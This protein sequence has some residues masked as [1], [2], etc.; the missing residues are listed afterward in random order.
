LLT[1]TPIAIP[2][3]DEVVLSNRN[4]QAEIDYSV[5]TTGA[6]TTERGQLWTETGVA[7]WGDGNSSTTTLLPDSS[8]FVWIGKATHGYADRLDHNVTVVVTSSFSD[9]NNYSETYPFHYVP[10]GPAIGL[11]VTTDN[12]LTTGGTFGP[13][14]T[15]IS[16]KPGFTATVSGDTTGQADQVVYSVD[17][18]S[19]PQPAMDNGPDQWIIPLD[20]GTLTGTSATHTLTVTVLNAAGATLGSPVTDT[21]SMQQ[22]LNFGTL[23]STPPGSAPPGVDAST[24]RFFAGV[25]VEP[26]FDGTI[27]DL[28][29]YYAN[30]DQIPGVMIGDN[31]ALAPDFSIVQTTQDSAAFSFHTDVATLSPEGDNSVSLLGAAPASAFLVPFPTGSH[32]HVIA[33]PDWLRFTAAG[34]D[35][36][37][38]TYTFDLTYPVAEF[39]LPLSN[40]DS[41]DG[42]IDALINV[43]LTQPTSLGLGVNLRVTAALTTNPGDAVLKVTS[44]YATATVLGENL[45][46]KTSSAFVPSQLFVRAALDPETLEAP[47]GISLTT[48]QI[49]IGDLAN[50]SLFSKSF[51]GSLPLIFPA[52]SLL[53]ANVSIKTTFQARLTSLAVSAALKLDVTGFDPQLS[54]GTF[55]EVDA[56]GS[57]A[58]TLALG[59]SISFLGIPLVNATAAGY[60]AAV[61]HTNLRLDFTGPI[62][63]PKAMLDPGSSAGINFGYGITYGYSTLGKPIQYQTDFNPTPISP[64]LFGLKP[65]PS[66]DL[67]SLDD[68]LSGPGLLDS[69]GLPGVP[70][71]IG[72]VMTVLGSILGSPSPEI[73]TSSVEPFALVREDA[74]PAP[75]SQLTLAT[76]VFVPVSDLTFDLDVLSDQASLAAGDH[77][78]DV[79]LVGLDG[80]EVPLKSIDLAS[81]VLSTN[82]NPLG[83]ASGWKTIDVPITQGEL[84][85][86]LPYQLEFRLS[87]DSVAD[88]A[89][90]A[91]ALDHLTTSRLTPKL[92]V[93]SASAD[94]Q[95]GTVNF[96]PA[97]GSTGVET[98]QLANSGQAPLHVYAPVLTGTNAALVNPPLVGYVLLPGESTD[99]QV[100]VLDPSQPANASLRISSD[101]PGQASFSLRL[102]Y[103]EP[104]ESPATPPPATPPPALD[105]DTGRGAFVTMLYAK[106][107]GR[108][109]ELKGFRFWTGVLGRG[110]KPR[111]VAVAIWNSSERRGLVKQ[112]L[113]PPITFERSYADALS[114]KRHAARHAKSRRLL[115]GAK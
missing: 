40:L 72:T 104:G 17:D 34:F 54:S 9:G 14:I 26:T 10:S 20:V 77:T 32:L 16:F 19:P 53:G 71:S 65:L 38:G 41:D 101:D 112:G 94:I 95:G 66:P 87:T 97:N 96:G 15:G 98:I 37:A 48:G 107:L 111:T 45:L 73:K 22:T 81:S 108:R 49:P 27:T 80:S 2:L 55:V 29:F 57:G 114:A 52:L 100:Q 67:T 74:V 24:L 103:T 110:V 102:S 79:V 105:V 61:A 1:H 50:K 35:E 4:N 6:P 109:P 83:F 21:L 115:I 18:E 69:A 3:G 44:W 33:L 5:Y 86:G 56:A 12:T 47:K 25:S 99:L 84:V 93:S 92:V 63:G 75:T 62:T 13:Y 85:A 23:K 64:S 51:G 89:T 11:S 91:V 58:A 113:I 76:P 82:G 7:T 90:V 39:S 28:P 106:D 36:T 78:L 42:Y 60:L 59:G 88:G 30:T 31:Q 46:D 70:P 43:I 68:I 8:G